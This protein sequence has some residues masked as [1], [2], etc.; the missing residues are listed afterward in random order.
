MRKCNPSVIMVR[1]KDRDMNTEYVKE[2]EDLA[3]K[4]LPIYN[5]YY[6]L[7]GAPKPELQMPVVERLQKQQPALF[8][9]WPID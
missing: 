2:L 5:E 6:R 9:P 1:N 4:L 8:K 3:R 7:T